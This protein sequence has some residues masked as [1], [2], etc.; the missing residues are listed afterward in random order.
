MSDPHV[1]VVDLDS[2]HAGDTGQLPGD[3]DARPVRR[4]VAERVAAAA[5]VAWRG[6]VEA[7]SVFEWIITIGALMLLGG[8]WVWVGPGPAFTGVGALVVWM[9]IAGG[10]AAARAAAQAAAV[11]EPADEPGRPVAV[12]VG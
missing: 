4:T 8:L 1:Q 2:E 5:G 12:E 3:V 11:D 10:R 6:L 7:F 9:G